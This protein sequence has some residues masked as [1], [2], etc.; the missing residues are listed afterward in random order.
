MYQVKVSADNQLRLM[1]NGGQR[2]TTQFHSIPFN[3]QANALHPGSVIELARSYGGLD[4]RL[5]RRTMLA[6]ITL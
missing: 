1:L 3:V 6:G 5:T 2:E 4:V